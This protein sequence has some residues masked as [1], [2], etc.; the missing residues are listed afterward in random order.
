M[1]ITR[2]YFFF[3]NENTFLNELFMKGDAIMNLADYPMTDRTKQVHISL[4]CEK[5]PDGK[6]I[7]AIHNKNGKIQASWKFKDADELL[8][9]GAMITEYAEGMTVITARQ[10]NNL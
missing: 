5:Y 6:P 3:R 7:I 2:S 8:E 1:T 9:F 4:S 10:K